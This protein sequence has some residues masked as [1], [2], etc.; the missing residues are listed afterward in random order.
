[1]TEF[2]IDGRDKDGPIHLKIEVDNPFAGGGR[3]VRGG[4]H[5]HVAQMGD[6]TTVCEQY[7]DMGFDF[8]A[9]TDYLDIT[10]LPDSTDT[11][12]TLS[13]AEIFY[14]EQD[15][16]THIIC[17]GLKEPVRPLRD[18]LNDVSR[19]VRDVESQG[20]LAVLAHPSW[21]GYTWEK[22]F[23]LTRSGVVG[24]ELSNRL[25]WQI[26]GKERSEELWQ[27]L[28]NE[29]VR[30]A[31]IGVDDAIVLSDRTVMGQTWT[32]VMVPRL[33]EAEVL[34]GIREH[35][36]YA[37]EG[38]EIR[39][40]RVESKGAIIVESSPVRACH[41]R[42][43]GFGVRSVHVEGQA[44]LFEVDLAVDGYR[45]QDWISICVEDTAGRRAWS[46][47]IPVQVG[48]TRL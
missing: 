35:R 8:L 39:D 4:L 29:G 19:L 5:S 24:F 7:Q 21:S 37:S 42:S 34:S 26:N 48:V 9:A 44:D 45:M 3:W 27:M 30:L 11:F 6:P 23:A 36:T 14:P 47:A 20:G 40:I 18:T 28:L 17:L 46:S 12:V 31:A 15:D 10:P 13:G 16:L 32:G 43:R 38:P 41:V 33:G 2:E 22:A 1:M 25:T